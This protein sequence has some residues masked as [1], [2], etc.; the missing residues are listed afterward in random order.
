MLSDLP[1]C[2]TE[3]PD[4]TRVEPPPAELQLFAAIEKDPVAH[5]A[6]NSRPA[7]H[8]HGENVTRSKLREPFAP[9]PAL[10]IAVVQRQYD[11]QLRIKFQR[12]TAP[13]GGSPLQQTP[14]NRSGQLDFKST[15]AEVS[16]PPWLGCV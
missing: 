2:G 11:A 13:V 10:F 3:P 14:R 4:Q 1:R 15:A 8:I 5:E 7:I 12:D 16:V 6:D 9:H